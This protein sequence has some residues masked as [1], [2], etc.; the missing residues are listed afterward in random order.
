VK[1]FIDGIIISQLKLLAM[2][3]SI[4]KPAKRISGIFLIM[5]ITLLSCQKE[6]I[7]QPAVT[8]VEDVV[9]LTHQHYLKSHD[10]AGD[11]QTPF[12]VFNFGLI[13]EYL[14]TDNH[15]VRSGSL[16]R[17][18]SCIISTDLTT[19][20]ATMVRRAVMA[21]Q[22][23]NESLIAKHREDVSKLNA[24]MEQ[25]RKS[26]MLQYRNGELSRQELNNKMTQ[27]RERYTNALANIKE[28]NSG[29]FT[30][31]FRQLMEHIHTILTSE[32][33]E[34]MANCLSGKTR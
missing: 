16:N 27:L 26:L 22:K 11:V 7:D 33:W 4:N 20:Q 14:A 31:S 19:D 15:F 9:E 18:I 24:A 30:R 25:Y 32:Q 13:D 1:P 28:S 29:A 12:T 3:N 5:L 23:R 34:S 21:Y 6:I 8:T 10:I 2:I 17:L